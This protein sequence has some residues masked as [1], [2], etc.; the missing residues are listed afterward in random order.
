M[1]NFFKK[2]YKYK[3]NFATEKNQGRYIQSMHASVNQGDLY[4]CLRLHH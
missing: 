1:Y 2:S 3:K 4:L